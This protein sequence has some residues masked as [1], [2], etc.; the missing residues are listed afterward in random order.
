MVERILETLLPYRSVIIWDN[1]V[2]EDRMVFGRYLAMSEAPTEVCYTQDDDCIVPPETQ[3]ALLNSYR[4]GGI[5]SNYAHGDN[6]GGYGDLPMPPGG[7]LYAVVEAWVSIGAYRQEYG[8]DAWGRDE[9]AYADFVVGVL[10]PFQQIH[11]PFQINVPVA[12]HPS[13]LCNQPW[14]AQAKADVTGRARKIRDRELAAA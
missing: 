2:R 8:I 7:A 9:D 12:Q 11:A 4:P 14:A 10:T 3:R 13:R 6:D 1:S 5:T